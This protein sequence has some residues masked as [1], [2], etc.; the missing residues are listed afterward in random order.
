MSLYLGAVDDDREILY[1]LEVMASSLGW[2]MRTSDDPEIA[3]NWVSDDTVDV[4]LVDFHMPIM[5]G[6]EVIRRARKLSSSVVLM[7]LTV[8]ERPDVARELIMAGADDFVSKPIRLADFSARIGL[9]RELS[10]YRRA[11]RWEGG[12]RGISEDTARKVYDSLLSEGVYL[13]ASE[14]ADLTGVS[15]PTANR[16]LE[17]LV[18]KGQI[19]K[20][21]RQEDGRSGRPRSYYCGGLP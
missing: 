2:S 21:R 18:R 17:Y 10:R 7:A 4:L 13:S 3:L 15:Y 12:D 20:M 1:T 5:S 14:V 6:L 16:Y 8:E 11:G 9:H 19:K